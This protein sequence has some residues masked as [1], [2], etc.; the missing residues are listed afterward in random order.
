M[1]G[2]IRRARW[3]SSGKGQ[4]EF[5][6]LQPSAV[7]LYYTPPSRFSLHSGPPLPR[8]SARGP[9]PPDRAASS[10]NGSRGNRNCAHL[11][12]ACA[13]V[14]GNNLRVSRRGGRRGRAAHC[15][16]GGHTPRTH[17]AALRGEL[18]VPRPV[19]QCRSACGR[20]T[21]TSGHVA[22][23]G[24]DHARRAGGVGCCPRA[25]GQSNKPLSLQHANLGPLGGI[26]SLSVAGAQRLLAL[27]VGRRHALPGQRPTTDFHASAVA[28]T[29]LDE[30]EPFLV[31]RARSEPKPLAPPHPRINWKNRGRSVDPI[32]VRSIRS[33]FPVWTCIHRIARVAT[34]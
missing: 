12:M 10:I 27:N 25:R 24:V 9:R 14:I 8:P 3:A 30:G 19:F 17:T 11:G 18:A 15:L 2:K 21:S 32:L 23:A 22:C 31:G 20:D 34:V 28:S 5:N 4:T 6:A 16:A 26:P 29:T 7:G 13:A 33:P 1:R